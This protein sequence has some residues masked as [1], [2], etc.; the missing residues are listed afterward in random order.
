MRIWT[1]LVPKR[2]IVGMNKIDQELENDQQ[3]VTKNLGIDKFFLGGP[4]MFSLLNINYLTKWHSL[5]C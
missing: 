2:L 3:K 5:F 4:K 1:I